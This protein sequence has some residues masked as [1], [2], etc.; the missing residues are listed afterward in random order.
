MQEKILKASDWKERPTYA[1]L[2]KAILAAA[3]K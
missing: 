3:K 1:Q 2:I